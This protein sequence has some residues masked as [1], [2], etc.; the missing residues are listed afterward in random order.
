[1]RGRSGRMGSARL[2]CLH[3][4]DLTRTRQVCYN[5]GTLG[6]YLEM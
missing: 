2:L 1:M 5:P 3:A 4:L 6:G